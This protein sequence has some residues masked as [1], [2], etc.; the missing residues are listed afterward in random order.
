MLQFVWKLCCC[1]S[2]AHIFVFKSLEGTPALCVVAFYPPL[3]V[4]FECWDVGLEWSCS[5]CLGS[6]MWALRLM[7]CNYF[8]FVPLS[9]LCHE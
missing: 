7:K 5:H 8:E 3:H 9:M 6:A 4:A 1:H 2:A